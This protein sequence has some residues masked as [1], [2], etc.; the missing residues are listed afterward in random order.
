M[1]RE[2]QDDRRDERREGARTDN[3]F[4]PLAGF[5]PSERT[6][7]DNLTGRHQEKVRHLMGREGHDQLLA[8]IRRLEAL[9]NEKQLKKQRLEA[10]EACAACE[11]D[12]AEGMDFTAA[13]P[14]RPEPAETRLFVARPKGPEAP[15]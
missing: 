3:P 1:E 11:A 9:E 8:E 6:E 12:D 5:S 13:E 7:F 15:N 10:D 4:A 14:V 2:N